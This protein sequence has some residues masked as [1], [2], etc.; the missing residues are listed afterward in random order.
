VGGG[1]GGKIKG[2]KV[3]RE[4]YVGWGS[5]NQKTSITRKL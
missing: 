1:G 5:A 4:K 2:E 3:L